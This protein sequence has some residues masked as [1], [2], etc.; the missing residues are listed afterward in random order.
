VRKEP[1]STR[2]GKTLR[3]THKKKT[4]VLAHVL[5]ERKKR[6]GGKIEEKEGVWC[7]NVSRHKTGRSYIINKSKWGIASTGKKKRKEEKKKGG[8]GEEEKV[9]KEGEEGEKNDSLVRTQVPQHQMTS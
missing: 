9:K 1:Y 4:L 3:S 7:K 6:E 5:G 8:K 2:G